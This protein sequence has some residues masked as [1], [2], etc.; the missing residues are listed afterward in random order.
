M[1]T[2]LELFLSAVGSGGMAVSSSPSRN[3][4][5]SFSSFH[6]DDVICSRTKCGDFACRWS[7]TRTWTPTNCVTREQLAEELLHLVAAVQ[8]Q[9]AADEDIDAVTEATIQDGD[10][11]LAL[12]FVRR[13]CRVADFAAAVPPPLDGAV[14]LL[15]VVAAPPLDLL[16]FVGARRGEENVA[17]PGSGGRGM[18]IVVAT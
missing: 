5:G 18:T 13:V 16:V 1:S 7:K 9:D 2:A 10:H 3:S 17:A 15:V 11:V 6:V 4:G 12:I 8:E 14:V